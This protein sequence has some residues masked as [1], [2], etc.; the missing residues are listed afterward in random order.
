MNF[1]NL[2]NRTTALLLLTCCLQSEARGESP[3]KRIDFNRD[4]RP[5]LSNNCYPCHG[6]DK[7]KRKADLRLD[8]KA[9]LYAER[10]DH[11]P[12]VEG[13]PGE[14]ELYRRITA[15]KARERMPPEKSKLQLRNSEIEL[16]RAWIEQG[17]HWSGHWAFRSLEKTAVPALDGPASTRNAIDNF[18]QSRLRVEGLEPTGE[19]SREK[20]IRRLSL[21]LTGLPPTLAQIDAFLEDESPE[22]YDKL[23]D[24]LL[25]SPAYGERM[26]SDWLDVARYSDTY[27]Y[28]VDRDRF[29]WPWRDWVVKA[30]NADIPYDEFITLQLAG[31]LLPK[32][33]DEQILP[34]TFNRLHSQKVEGGSTPEEFRVEYVADRTHTFATAFLG[35]SIECARCHDHKYDPVTQ[36]EYYKLF[37][38]FNNIDEFG[39]YAYFTGSVP[40]PTLLYASKAHKQKIA[41]AAE[42]ISRAEEDLA[43]I[44]AAAK[45]GFDKWLAS[46]PAE[47]AIPGRIEHQDFEAHKGGGNA[48]IPGV[49][50]KAIRLSGDDE[51][52]LKQG[53]FQRS[54][55]FSF[56]LWMKTP[57]VKDRAIVFHRSQA[58]TDAGSRGYQLLLEE[59]KLSFSLIH[60]WPGNAL[61]I[62]TRA[63]FEVNKWVHVAIT[64]DGSSRADGARLFLDGTPADCEIVRDNLFKNITGGGGRNSITIGARFR[65]KGF[66]GGMV[67][68]F[69]VFNRQLSSLEIAQVHDGKSLAEALLKPGNAL[70]GKL[71][72]E[73]REYY[74]H[75]AHDPWKKGL[76]R[77][78]SLRKAHNKIIDGTTEIMVMKETG[79]VRQTHLLVRGAYNKPGVPVEAGTP[80]ILPALKERD[81]ANRLGL[82]H[83]LTDPKHPLTSRVMVNRLWQMCFGRGLVRTTEDFGSQGESPSHPALLDWLSLRF[84]ESGWDIRGLIK[85]IVTSTTYRQDS[86]SSP[87]LREKDPENILLARGRR[88]RLSA[89]VIRDNALASSGLLVRKVGGAPVRPYEVTVSFK[90]MK[91]DKGEGLYRRSL[92]TFWK[93]TAPAPVMMSLDAPKREV[94]T[95]RRERTA[96]PLQALVLMNDPQLV[97][98]ARILGQR[99]LKKHAGDN[100]AMLAEMFRILTGRHPG[101]NENEILARLYREQL[102][103]FQANAENAKGFLKTGDAAADANIPPARLAAAGAV[104]NVLLNF[105]E[106]VMKR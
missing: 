82:A 54:V 4:I 16:I 23:V 87:A 64:Y 103:F 21:D 80:A 55:P 30:F 26:A 66:A 59:G 102:E 93:R 91:R 35:L 73:L 11:R 99:M 81:D 3:E 90:P 72:G 104:A 29:V 83:W 92:Y 60:F 61:R 79:K 13:K 31:D 41:D 24:R 88:Y 96:S 47:P 65:D 20:L 8:L 34:T 7:N 49:S 57:E 70:G 94:C 6:P 12:V 33:D 48:S 69:Q 43:K 36:K 19:A 50:G 28:Q 25:S 105:D 2:C 40:T 100:A 44:P 15:E 78:L 77:I 42:K 101:K 5:I 14:S 17:A 52:H 32:A 9:G 38:F 18:I 86:Y 95:V 22:A 63:P 1:R 51:Y 75:T 27:G 39:L 89:E 56:A 58:W 71:L 46:R 97:E 106:A 10:D 45:A 74:L 98:A 84:I 76:E 53:N 85:T 67:D 68:E 62:R 37:A